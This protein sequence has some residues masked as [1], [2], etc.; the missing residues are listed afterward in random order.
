MNPNN[1][2]FQGRVGETLETRLNNLIGKTITF[3]YDGGT[4]YGT[5]QGDVRK[6][7]R[8]NSDY[9]I[10]TYDYSQN[11]IR[12]F[13]FSKMRGLQIVSSPQTPTDECEIV[14][15]RTKVNR[16][17]LLVAAGIL[18][19]AN[20]NQEFQINTDKSLTGVAEMLYK[21]AMEIK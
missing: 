12:N 8:H 1:F 21:L 11:G 10:E 5:R 14:V 6:V 17:N 13:Y 4:I 3:T 19:G 20:Q 16:E 18:W 2:A 9:L 15:D 7:I